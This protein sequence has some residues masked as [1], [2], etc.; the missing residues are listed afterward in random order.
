MKLNQIFKSL[1]I[2]TALFT[3]LPATNVNAA[4]TNDTDLSVLKTAP[5]GIGISNYMSN[6]KPNVYDSKDIYDTN[7]A[8]IVDHSGNNSTSGNVIALASGKNTYGSMW[9]TDKSFDINKEQTISAWLY[10]GSGD[11]SSDVNSEG[12]TFVLQ[13]DSNGIAALGAGL[14]LSLI[15]I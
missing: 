14:E 2:A 9:S 13:N 7:S 12:I 5:N 10:F 11:G 4:L 3:I 15:H 6:A 8:Q 1:I